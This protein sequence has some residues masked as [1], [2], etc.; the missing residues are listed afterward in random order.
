MFY[1]AR[2]APST[3]LLKNTSTRPHRLED[4]ASHQFFCSCVSQLRLTHARPRGACVHITASTSKFAVPLEYRK[5]LS[6][7][8]TL[9]AT[10]DGDDD[11]DDDDDDDDGDDDDDDDDIVTSP[12]FIC[13]IHS[14][15][16]GGGS[17]H[18]N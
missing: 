8:G 2:T 11:E 1:V 14:I 15:G 18:F 7:E 13:S 12:T 17:S 3:S 4:K 9:Q 5:S 6:D 16:G 10:N